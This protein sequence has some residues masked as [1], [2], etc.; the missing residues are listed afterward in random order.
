MTRPVFEPQQWWKTVV[1][2]HY[3]T[4]KGAYINVQIF[5]LLILTLLM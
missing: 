3:G 5:M 2:H 1:L 4:S